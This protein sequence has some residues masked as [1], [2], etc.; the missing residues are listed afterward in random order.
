[1]LYSKQGGPL[2]DYPT[3]LSF[4]VVVIALC[5]GGTASPRPRLEEARTAR[6]D[7]APNG[8]AAGPSISVGG[9]G[10]WWWDYEG[11]LSI[12]LVV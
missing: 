1:M 9:G 4:C 2:G 7:P 3:A 8:R 5:S 6:P 12:R 11:H 10:G